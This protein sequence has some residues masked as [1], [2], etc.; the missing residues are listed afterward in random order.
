MSGSVMQDPIMRGSILNGP[1]GEMLALVCRGA[2]E[3]AWRY[4][5]VF[6]MIF[7]SAGY[8]FPLFTSACI[9]ALS[10]LLNRAAARKGCPV[11]QVV[12]LNCAGFTACALL[13]LHH[14]RYPAYPFW[15][16]EWMDRLV[17]DPAGIVEWFCLVL[18]FFCLAVIWQGGIYLKKKPGTYLAVGL[19]FDKGLG[20][21]FALLIVNAVVKSRA[22]VGLPA[23]ALGFMMPAYLI[24]GLAAVGLS[25]HQHDV[26][27]S[28]LSGYR[29]LGIIFSLA[30]LVILLGSGL[31]LLFHPYLFPM[32]DTLLAALD[33]A[34]TP[35]VPHLV[36]FI[37]FYLTPRYRVDL[38]GT[39][40][41]GG[42]AQIELSPPP[43]GGWMAGVA[44][45]LIWATMVVV[46]L[47]A[48]GFMAYLLKRLL[49]WLLSKDALEAPPLTF[50]AWVLG[51]WKGLIALPAH[52]WRLAASLFKRMDSAA[53]VYARLLD[54]GRRC[55]LSKRRNE[56][57]DEYGRR[58]LHHF[59]QLEQEI[60][61]IVEAFDW[62]VYGLGNTGPDKLAD[63]L[64]AQRRMKRMR[65]WPRRIKVWLSA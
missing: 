55:G 60:R 56:T 59:P 10:A 52:L 5:W 28:F 51:L 3:L 37:R 13:F 12:L 1:G 27:K 42:A 32:A 29:G 49:A 53:L 36:R 23:N 11:Y 19:Q 18:I 16:L 62:E 64:R 38:A 22:G 57:P 46:I 50:R 14:L 7:L 26:K 65:Y 24:F 61:L 34:T 4:A 25:R 8:R 39:Q 30:A 20:W 47:M 6:F 63:I 21:L 45:I 17:G 40:D 15:R 35:M 9:L 33:Q 54:W 44:E 58:L 41:D 48:A 43:A 2:M 31:A